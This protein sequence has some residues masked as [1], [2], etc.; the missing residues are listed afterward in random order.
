MQDESVSRGHIPRH[1]KTY[2]ASGVC[3]SWRTIRRALSVGAAPSPPRKKVP[4][5][6]P[7]AIL[8]WSTTKGAARR[9]YLTRQPRE[10]TA[11]ATPAAPTPTSPYQPIFPK[12]RIAFTNKGGEELEV[13]YRLL[14]SPSLSIIYFITSLSQTPLTYVQHS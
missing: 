9:R 2:P 13:T 5:H 1:L 8:H 11:S 10:R 14:T 3:S 4:R 7:L 6:F 12:E